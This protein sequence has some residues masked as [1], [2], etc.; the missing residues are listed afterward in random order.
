MNRRDAL[1][2]VFALGTLPLSSFAQPATPPKRIGWLTPMSPE[3]YK[4]AIE[5]F[6]AKMKELGYLEGRDFVFERRQGDGRV[7]KL[8]A[9]VREILGSKP[10]VIVTGTSAAVAAFRKETNSVP[11]VFGGASDVVEQGFVASLARPGGNI[12]GVTLRTEVFGKLVQLIRETLPSAR[13]IALLLDESDPLA[14]RFV[15]GYGQPASVQGF[16]LSAVR[17]KRVEDLERAFAEM[18]REKAEAVIVPQMALLAVNAKPIA[19]LALK[20][21]LPIFSSRRFAE[22]GCLV[23]Y[24][25]DIG[26]S[27]RRVASLVDKIFK[28]AKPAD[29]PVE[30][31]DRYV[32]DINLRTAK[33]LGKTIPQSVLVRADRVIE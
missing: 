16:R 17:V 11:I 25:S 6:T 8:P 28:G 22:D 10:A 20:T 5:A 24:Y 15:E 19:T 21:R 4:S 29:L 13:R 27:Y 31:P 9:L 26:E 1:L 23:S 32:L 14:N 3:S 7:D 12:T 33:A 2:V 30:E 18:S